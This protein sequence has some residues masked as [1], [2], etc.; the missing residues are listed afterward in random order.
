MQ[1]ERASP[2]YRLVRSDDSTLTIRALLRKREL[3][4]TGYRIA[5]SLPSCDPKRTSLSHSCCKQ[6]TANLQLQRLVN[7]LVLYL[8][9]HP[10][11]MIQAWRQMRSASI[12][13]LCINWLGSHCSLPALVLS[14]VLSCRYRR[15]THQRLSHLHYRLSLKLSWLNLYNQGA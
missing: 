8:L 14:L 13:M 6:A 15:R 2:K 4:I 11:T 12:G 7:H 9:C 1:S 5:M 10:G 3:R